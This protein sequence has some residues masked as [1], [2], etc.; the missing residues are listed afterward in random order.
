[1][2]SS[3]IAA[4]SFLIVFAARYCVMAKRC[5]RVPLSKARRWAVIA[6]SSTGMWWASLACAITPDSPGGG[7][8]QFTINSGDEVKA[9][10]PWIYGTNFGEVANARF[11]R[12]GGNRLTGYNWENNASN[13]G[14]DWYHHN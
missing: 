14:S 7:S 4:R 6:L 10:S 3:A 5:S 11:N 2:F 8:V 13:A 12:S 1:A 9:I